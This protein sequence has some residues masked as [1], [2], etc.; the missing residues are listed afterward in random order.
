MYLVDSKFEKLKELDEMDTGLSRQF[1][2]KIKVTSI[3]LSKVSNEMIYAGNENRGYEIL[4]FDLNGK[5]LRKIK[6]EYIPVDA[7][8]EFKEA[9]IASSPPSFKNKL[10]FDKMPPFHYFF[11][12]DKGRLYVKTYE[13]GDK[14]GEYIHDIFD[15]SGIFIA[16]KSM[17]GYGDPYNPQKALN[18]AKAKNNRL[19]C[20]RENE[21]GFKELVVYKMTWE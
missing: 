6:K 19:Y 13:K 8:E 21:S 4:I 17:A 3:F 9:V 5:L 11:L 14:Q 16:R 15:A 10:Y 12:D 18:R 7:P 2:D 20:I 1:A